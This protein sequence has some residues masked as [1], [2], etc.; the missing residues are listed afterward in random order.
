M[1]KISSQEFKE[2][3]QKTDPIKEL[4]RGIN[5]KRIEVGARFD[6]FVRHLGG[7][8]LSILEKNLKSGNPNGEIPRYEIGYLVLGLV[9]SYANDG[10]YQM[11]L[12]LLNKSSRYAV[13][14]AGTPKAHGLLYVALL[15]SA[16]L[17]RLNE[18]QKG[19]NSRDTSNAKIR[20]SLGNLSQAVV[21]YYRHVNI[22]YLTPKI[23]KLM[24]GRN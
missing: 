1:D 18:R 17:K 9:H 16:I 24:T 15:H 3:H 8:G 20:G 12:D 6:K 11:A 4:Y 23:E 13:E 19:R 14:A 10:N 2:R 5:S 7:D 22:V 21:N